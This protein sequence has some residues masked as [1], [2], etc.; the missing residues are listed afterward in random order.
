MRIINQAGLSP[1]EL[2]VVEREIPAHRSL[3][4]VINWGL[5][6]ESG[7][8]LPEVVAEVLAQDEFSHDVIIPWRDGLVLV[9]GTT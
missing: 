7:A 3:Q 1:D 5:T 6:P 8:L 2:A 9:Y 4:E